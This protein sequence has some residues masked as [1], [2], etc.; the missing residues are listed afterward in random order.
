M[1]TIRTPVAERVERAGVSDLGGADEFLDDV[2]DVPGGHTGGLIDGKQS[3][4]DIQRCTA[5]N[6]SGNAVSATGPARPIGVRVVVVIEIGAV[7]RR[8]LAGADL[9]RVTAFGG[10]VGRQ[11]GD[12]ARAVRRS[13]AALTKPWNSGWGCCG[14]DLNSG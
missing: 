13:C 3:V 5:G 7:S 6:V 10:D 9:A 8:P 4:H 11:A 1:Q 2:D 14:F 12:C